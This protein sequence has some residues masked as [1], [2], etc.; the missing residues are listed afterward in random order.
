MI[1]NIT[2]N[3][4][5]TKSIRLSSYIKDKYQLNKQSYLHVQIGQWQGLLSIDRAN[6]ESKDLIELSSDVINETQ[7]LTDIQYEI[8]FRDKK[9]YIGPVIGIL[10]PRKLANIETKNLKIYENYLINYDQI[11]GM[12]LLFTEDGII[13]DKKMVEGFV[14]HPLKEDWE[15]NIYPFP[16]AFFTRKRINLPLQEKLRNQI[17]A[18]FF[19]SY[20]FNKWEMWQ[21]LSNFDKI[22][23]ILPETRLLQS[24]YDLTFMLN[25]HNTI[26]IKPI[27][28]MKGL[29]VF[30]VEKKDNRFIL[31]F[32]QDNENKVDYYEKL[33]DLIHELSTHMKWN[34]YLVQQHINL[35]QYN[36]RK[37]DIRVILQ[38]GSQ[39]LWK[40]LDM[41]SRYGEKESI[42][43]NIS[44]GG[45]AEKTWEMLLRF[46]KKNELLAYEKYLEIE[47]LAILIGKNLES[48]NFQ[49]GNLGV[50]IGMDQHGKIW[51]IE[52]NNWYPDPTIAF[53]ANDSL[54]YYQVKANP[55]KYAKWLAGFRREV[56]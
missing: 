16:S 10:I 18:S 29:G 42:V 37:T 30:Q 22:K 35:Y 43:S 53:D 11:K 45:I 36:G 26:F 13:W 51:L 40:V 12:I 33:D 25:K 27:S 3:N 15:R 23:A 49:F 54:L 20:T 19:N 44:R 21:W 14:Y 48:N 24:T 32:R 39:G 28:G 38:K 31:S 46:Y 4:S 17:G 34:K 50:D 47:E 1:I 5:P 7:V 41:I 55:L 56:K 8:V 2:V 6:L 52:I 9:L